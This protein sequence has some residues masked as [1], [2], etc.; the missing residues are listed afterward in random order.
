MADD[1]YWFTEAKIHAKV[2]AMADKFD[3]HDLQDF[4]RTRSHV[5]AL[6]CSMNE[7]RELIDLVCTTI[8]VLSRGLRAE[9]AQACMNHMYLIGN[10]NESF[11]ETLSQ[12]GDMGAELVRKMNDERNAGFRLASEFLSE[13]NESYKETQRKLEDL[14][15]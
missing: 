5:L 9:I 10:D 6:D 4:A 7:L 8:P 12:Y 14:E 11:V 2:Y 1:S 15:T 3:I 13:E